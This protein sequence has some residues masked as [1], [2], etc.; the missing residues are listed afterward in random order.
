MKKI[1]VGTD[2]LSTWDLEA[3]NRNR[4]EGVVIEEL[5]YWYEDGGYD[6]SGTAVYLDNMGDWH[7]DGLGHC[8]CYG[9]FDDGFNRITYTKED[10]IALLSK[11]S[12]NDANDKK[13]IDAIS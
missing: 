2:E 6:G 7:Y 12:Y 8:S 5:Y 11:S 13:I 10:I 1:N 9:A 4:P 3:L